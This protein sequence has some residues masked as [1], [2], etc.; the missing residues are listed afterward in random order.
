MLHNQKRNYV[1]KW[2][3]PGVEVFSYSDK[4]YHVSNCY[5]SYSISFDDARMLMLSE[6]VIDK[7]QIGRATNDEILGVLAYARQ[8]FAM[9]NK[10]KSHAKNG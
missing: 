9:S 2:Y 6:G 5:M 3:P 10:T 1:D 7:Y 8:H 4:N